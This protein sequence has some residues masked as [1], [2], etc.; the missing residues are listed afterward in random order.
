MTDSRA[1]FD[2]SYIVRLYLE[3]VGFEQVREFASRHT[4]VS[5]VHGRTETIAAMHR[6]LRERRI[7]QPEFQVLVAQFQADCAEQGIH[8]LTLSESV[9]SRVESVY[10]N[11]PATQFLRA[12]DALHLACAREND[13][14]SIYSND[15]HLLAAA[16]IF[17][18]AGH[19][20]W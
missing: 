19:N 9:L 2:T 10:M 20:L 15:R 18:L 17:D 8:W 3:D 7:T 14:T 12:A 11:A 6:A 5:A 16:P 13:F 1:Y 4:I